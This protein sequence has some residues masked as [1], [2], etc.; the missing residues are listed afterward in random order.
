MDGGGERTPGRRCFGLYT[1]TRFGRCGACWPAACVLTISATAAALGSTCSNK[2]DSVG[3]G[4]EAGGGGY[5]ETGRGPR[6]HDWSAIGRCGGVQGASGRA[7]GE[8]RRLVI[9]VVIV[10]LVVVAVASSALL[11]TLR[12]QPKDRL[13][14]RRLE[15]VGGRRRRRSPQTVCVA[16]APESRRQWGPPGGFAGSPRTQPRPH[17]GT[18]PHRRPGRNG[19][20]ALG[21]LSRSGRGGCHLGWE[22]A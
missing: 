10:L 12:H 20:A 3:G 1:Q 18:R 2:G 17:R 19:A 22:H 9:C 8:T 6:C 7:E 5:A 16:T 4:R 14:A 11:A 13:R 21:E 15:R